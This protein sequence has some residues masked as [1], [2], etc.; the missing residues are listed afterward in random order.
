MRIRIAK[1]GLIL[2]R[3]RWKLNWML[4]SSI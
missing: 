3:N 4:S 2:N 1:L